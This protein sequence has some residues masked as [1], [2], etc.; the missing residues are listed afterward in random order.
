MQPFKKPVNEFESVHQHQRTMEALGEAIEKAH[1]QPEAQSEPQP[2][3][4]SR[5]ALLSFKQIMQ[6]AD[7]G[8]S[9]I[10]YPFKR[11]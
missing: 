4:E 7:R 8:E 1:P 11:V 5:F 2:S 3:A 9:I 6:H 10:I